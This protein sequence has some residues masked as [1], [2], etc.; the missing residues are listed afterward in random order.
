[1]LESLGAL[2][3]V[4]EHPMLEPVF[5]P[6]RPGEVHRSCLDV[7]RAKREPRLVAAVELVDGLRTILAE[8]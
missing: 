7:S 6:A 3:Y 8:L 5:E 1:V 2:R 4:A